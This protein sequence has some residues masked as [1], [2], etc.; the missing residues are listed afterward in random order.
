MNRY[1]GVK[2]FEVSEQSIF[3]GRGHDTDELLNLTL[4]EKI[5]V[6]FGKSGYGKSSLINAGLIPYFLNTPPDSDQFFQPIAIRFGNFI[7]ET[8][9]ISPTHRLRLKIENTL[10]LNPEGDFLQELVQEQNLWHQFKRRQNKNPQRILLLFDQ[11]EE[12]FSYPSIQ[13]NQFLQELEELIYTKIPQPIRDMGERI[14]DQNFEFLS[15]ELDIRVLF[16]IRADR[17]SLLDRLK[18]YLPSILD[19]RYELS[20]LKPADAEQAIAK[21]ASLQLENQPFDTPPFV[22]SPQALEAII[23]KLLEAREE[24]GGGI[25]AF[26]LQVICQEI[27]QRVESGKV[28]TRNADGVL[29]I[30]V[31]DLPP[32]ENIF[33]AYYKRQIGLLSTEQEQKAAQV[34]IE[35]GLLLLN[36]NNVEEARR[37]S[38]DGDALI[39]RYSSHGAG[40]ALL[41][42]LEDAFLVRREPNTT[43]GYNYEISHDTLIIPIANARRERR[44]EEAN[45]KALKAAEEA[46]EKAREEE[47]QKLSEKMRQTAERGRRR[48]IILAAIALALF[49]TSAIAFL[50]ARKQAALAKDKREEA[51]DRLQKYKQALFARDSL[52]FLWIKSRADEFASA[53]SLLAAPDDSLGWDVACELY[54][55]NEKTFL[56]EKEAFSNIN[57]GLDSI[58]REQYILTQ[59][60]SLRKKME[61]CE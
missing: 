60:D 38:V 46:K 27:E 34:V 29:E 5:S 32:F 24:S 51:E 3:F 1:P 53:A 49:F 59:L 14:S 47:R 52:N 41:N 7:D 9:S 50:Y 56:V 16:S 21:P 42:A 13:Q 35:D 37:L 39:E 31:E 33:E 28:N 40:Q 22:Y 54:R 57:P 15:R 48:A 61:Q 4:L 10:P 58:E 23:N 6:L 30:E 20:A 26:E 44:I 11:F 8:S 19:N 2:P 25:E 43:G 17:L 36:D 55:L 45:R 18:G 12:F